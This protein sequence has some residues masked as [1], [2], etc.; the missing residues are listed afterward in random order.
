MDGSDP[1]TSAEKKAERSSAIEEQIKEAQRK[2]EE[3]A[4]LDELAKRI[5]IAR[6]GRMF[7]DKKDFSKAITAYR[8]FLSI[9]AQA[10]SVELTDLKPQLFD[11]KSRNSESLLVSS[12]L[13]DMLKILDKIDT[14][15][16]KEERA[17]CHRLFIRFTLGQTFQMFA[18]EN[19]R[20]FIVYR[21]S[22]RHKSEFWATYQ[23][24]RVKK[25]CAVATWAYESEDAPEVDRLRRFRDERLSRSAAGRAF[26]RWYYQNGSSVVRILGRVPG[27][28]CAAK[29]GLDLISR[30]FFD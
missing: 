30:N 20:K 13:F 25:F 22:V 19:L 4:F 8:R 1:K 28:R 6:E 9:T 15:T 23:A 24:I 11:D 16:A 21:K 10:L 26:V 5:T 17:L 3:R 7:S 18:A 27:A 12:I 14:P 2:K 29:V